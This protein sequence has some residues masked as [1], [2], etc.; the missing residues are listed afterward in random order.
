[1]YIQSLIENK[2]CIQFYENQNCSDQNLS[3]Y[4][5]VYSN[6]F[7]AVYRSA[8]F[9]NKQIKSRLFRKSEEEI[10]CVFDDN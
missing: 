1:M 9:V 10:S 4:M 8:L 6:Y 3:N 2:V 7:K 5:Y